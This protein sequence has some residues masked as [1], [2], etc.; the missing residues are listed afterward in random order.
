[1]TL[2]RY[3]PRHKALSSVGAWRF[4][5]YPWL[6]VHRVTQV[7]NRTLGWHKRAWRIAVHAYEVPAGQEQKHAEFTKAAAACSLGDQIFDTRSQA[8]SAAQLLIES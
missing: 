4:Q 3:H 5:A 6:I 2:Q 8:V 1:M 7:Q